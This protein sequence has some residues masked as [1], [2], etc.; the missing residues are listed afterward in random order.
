MPSNMHHQ[1]QMLPNQM[2]SNQQQQ[3]QHP[4]AQQQ[5]P[6]FSQQGN[7]VHP[8]QQHSMYFLRSLSQKVKKSGLVMK[9]LKS[10]RKMNLNCVIGA[11]VINLKNRLSR[12]KFISKK[13]YLHIPDQIQQQQHQMMINS[14][15]QHQQNAQQQFMMQQ[16]QQQQP[17]QWPPQQRY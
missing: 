1:Q 16:Q 4:G 17:P 7:M 14:Q 3:Q 6:H 12:R 13:A 8:Q 11:H 5:H 9:F 10:L 15:Q 2:R